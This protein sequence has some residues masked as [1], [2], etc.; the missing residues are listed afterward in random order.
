MRNS[1]MCMFVSMYMLCQ[2]SEAKGRKVKSICF[3]LSKTIDL[4]KLHG[5]GP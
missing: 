4:M 5:R 3:F 1:C 2:I